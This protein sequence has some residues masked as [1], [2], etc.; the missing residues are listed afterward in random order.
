LPIAR[1]NGLELAGRPTSDVSWCAAAGDGLR[2]AFTL[3]GD[4]FMW[5]AIFLAAGI[6][7]CILGAECLVVDR[8]VMASDQP[9]ITEENPAT[10]FGAGPNGLPTAHRDIEPA[11][12]AAWS[13][14]SAGAVV[15]LY[16]L[17]INRQ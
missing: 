3:A 12:W 6:F 4:P 15:I 9:V 10:L 2:R 5:R 16:A 14:L 1:S 11:E 13:F 7:L 17:T 8:F